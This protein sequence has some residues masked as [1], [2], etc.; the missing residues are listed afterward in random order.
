MDPIHIIARAVF[1]SRSESLT[2]HH[3]IPERHTAAGAEAK[4]RASG[5]PVLAASIAESSV[6][7]VSSYPASRSCP[8]GLIHYKFAGISMNLDH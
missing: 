8:A 2:T 3:S 4:R 1:R 6:D 7:L 5:T